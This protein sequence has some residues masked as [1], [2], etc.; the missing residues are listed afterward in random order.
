VL[1][2]AL[3]VTLAAGF[4]WPELEAVGVVDVP[5]VVSQG[6]PTYLR[7]VKVKQKLPEL[8]ALFYE[9]FVKA[10]LWVP[11]PPRLTREPLLTAL[12][13]VKRRSYTV[14]FQPNPDGTTTLVLGE[15]DLAAKAA[16]PGVLA[17]LFPG[18]E[19]VFRSLQELARV[20]AYEAA[21]SLSE[22][23]SFYDETLP[24]GGWLKQEEGVFRRGGEELSVSV[25]PDGVRARVVLVA[26][27]L[28]DAK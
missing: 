6:V 13:P 12:D 21:A 5:P 28:P 9:S 7:A 10:G 25:R 16:E 18:A 14:V 24:K 8:A 20:E 11:K 4:H 17:P 23:R 22:V 26:R 19:K 27:R 2:A 3:C 1:S 15:A